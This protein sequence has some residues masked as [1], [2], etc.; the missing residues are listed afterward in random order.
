MRHR[1]VFAS[2]STKM[3]MIRT[4]VPRFCKK[5]AK[6]AKSAG[7]RVCSDPKGL[8]FSSPLPYYLILSRFSN[9]R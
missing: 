4:H 2:S 7:L 3:F 5:S 6:S 8:L 1:R 9:Q